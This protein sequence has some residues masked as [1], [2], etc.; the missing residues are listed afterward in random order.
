MVIQEKVVPMECTGRHKQIHHCAASGGKLLLYVRVYLKI[1][2][3]HT[4]RGRVCLC[5]TQGV[6]HSAAN[7]GLLFITRQGVNRN[8][9]VA[10]AKGI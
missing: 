7:L 10:A 1:T 3:Q 5:E 4:K 9:Q 2:R 6:C 8:E